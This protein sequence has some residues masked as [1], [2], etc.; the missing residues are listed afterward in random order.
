[1]KARI[2]GEKSILSW[3]PEF[4]VVISQVSALDILRVE[5]RKWKKANIRKTNGELI[6]NEAGKK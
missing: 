1:M 4:M 3:L 5:I 6:R 2:L